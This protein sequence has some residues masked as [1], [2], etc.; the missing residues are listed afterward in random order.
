MTVKI[1]ESI[2]RFENIY[3]GDTFYIHKKHICVL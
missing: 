3:V 2:L 1:N